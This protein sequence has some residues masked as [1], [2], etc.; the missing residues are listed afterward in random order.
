MLHVTNGDSAAEGLTQSGLSGDVLP[1]RDVLH[2]GPVPSD[3]DREAFQRT[4]SQ[5]IA[6]N[7]WASE[8]SVLEDLKSRDSR[9]DRGMSDDA[10][11]LWFEPD[12]YDQLQ[13]IQILSRLAKPESR[14]R[15][16]LSIVPADVLL[17]PLSPSGFPPLFD[18]RRLVLDEDLEHA[19]ASWRA[20]TS[21][22]P[23]ALVAMQARLEAEI[24]ARAY[25]DDAGTRLP[26]LAAALRRMLE[27]YPDATTGLSRSERQICEVL[28]SGPRKLSEL[29]PASHHAV[30]KWTWLG[31]WSFADYVSRVSECARP[32]ITDVNGASV[33]RRATQ[34]DEKSFWQR[35]VILTPF[36]TDVLQGRADAVAAN[37]IDKWIGG[38]HLTT[39]RHWRWDPATQRT[40]ARSTKPSPT[41]LS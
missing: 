18:A 41:A 13:L 5:F 40:D 23:D 36:G 12:L 37:G 4:R 17:G 1:W 7:D 38:A 33:P 21:A 15:V 6:G 19:G 39:D 28:A 2:D 8:Q 9:L 30:E 27:E 26:H 11:V 31:D 3:E 22:T 20:F 32:L 10:I 25:A 24:A 29:Y 34:G 14:E 16:M 35:T